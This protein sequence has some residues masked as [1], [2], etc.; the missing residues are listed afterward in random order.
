ML[1]LN[2]NAVAMLMMSL[3]LLYCWSKYALRERENPIMNRCELHLDLV[4]L[5][6]EL[7]L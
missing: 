4:F 5:V 6:D 7:G 3:Q 1:T 2:P